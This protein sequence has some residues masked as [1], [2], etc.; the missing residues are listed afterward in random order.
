MKKGNS[1]I[2]WYGEERRGQ[3][4][5]NA[6]FESK[7]ARDQWVQRD[8]T[9]YASNSKTTFA[10]KYRSLVRSVSLKTP[11]DGGNWRIIEKYA[12]A[13]SFDGP[14]TQAA[15]LSDL[16]DYRIRMAPFTHIDYQEIA[17][18]VEKHELDTTIDGKKAKIGDVVVD[19]L[20]DL[21][22]MVEKKINGK[23]KVDQE[24][25]TFVVS[26]VALANITTSNNP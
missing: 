25:R 7:S 5:D 23:I 18:H 22:D 10:R 19:N 12:R 9:H 8:N 2:Y 1:K 13:E 17:N 3:S 6:V 16:L 26:T 20:Q 4:V 15:N 11:V 21:L 14:L 24:N